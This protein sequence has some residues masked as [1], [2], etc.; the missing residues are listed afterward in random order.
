MTT[1]DFNVHIVVNM[2]YRYMS[3]VIWQEWTNTSSCSNAVLTILMSIDECP[4]M[5]TVDV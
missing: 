3:F 4:V 2:L 5:T 1:G